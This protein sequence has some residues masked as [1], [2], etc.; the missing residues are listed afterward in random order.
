MAGQY[1]EGSLDLEKKCRSEH[2]WQIS[3][4]STINNESF[5][6]SVSR[7]SVFSGSV[8]GWAVERRI[9]TSR[10]GRRVNMVPVK[11]SIMS[12]S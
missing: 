8:S 1:F 10:W 11:R 7:S 5:L 6:Q 12:I 3:P 9:S 2:V 4:T